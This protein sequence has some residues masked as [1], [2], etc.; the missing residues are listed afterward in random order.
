MHKIYVQ[1]LN[2][3]Y[4]KFTFKSVQFLAQLRAFSSAV[5]MSSGFVRRPSV[6]TYVHIYVCKQG[7]NCNY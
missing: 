2:C 7:T 6:S 4:V 3:E 1:N 5:L